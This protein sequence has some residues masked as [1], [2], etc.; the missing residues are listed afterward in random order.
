MHNNGSVVSVLALSAVLL[1]AGAS[2]AQPAAEQPPAAAQQQEEQEQEQAPEQDEQEPQQPPPDE[3]PTDAEDE[4]PTVAEEAEAE[5]GDEMAT[6]PEPQPPPAAGRR[7]TAPAAAEPA[8]SAPTITP[9]ALSPTGPWPQPD[10]DA[11]RLR[12]QGEARDTGQAQRE[13]TPDAQGVFAEDWWSHARPILE[14]HGYF[15]VRAELFHRMDLSRVNPPDDQLFPQPADSYYSNG[16]NTYG[17]VLCTADEAGLGDND[18]PN[19]LV[20]CRNRSLAGANLRFRLNPELHISD[21]LRVLSQVDLLDNLVLGSTPQGYALEPA[22]GGGYQTV[23]RGGYDPISLLD[24][25]QEPP[26][27]GVNGFR[28]SIRVK[29]AWAEYLTP[30]GEL[31][32]GRMPSHW[33][34]GILLNS[35]DGY[36]DDYQTTLDRIMFVTGVP[37]LDLFVAGAWDFPSEGATSEDVRQPQAQPYDAAQLDDVNQWALAIAKRKGAELTRLALAKGNLVLNGGAYLIY[38]KQLLANDLSG[39]V[40][41]G[42]YV[43]GAY[44]TAL[45]GPDG[46][47]PYVRRDAQIWTPDLWL[48]LL[49]KQFRF[50]LE[51]VTI[52]GSLE[53]TVSTGTNY[54]DYGGWKLRQYGIAT[55]IEQRLVE[56][57]LS[58]QF[59]FGWAS[60][61]PEA[62]EDLVGG[63]GLVPAPGAEMQTQ[64]GDDTFSTFRFHP[65]YRVDLILHRNILTRVQGDYYFRPSL[66]YDFMRSPNGQRF[67]GGFAGIWTRASEFMQTP[68]HRRDLG[69]ELNGQLY[70]QSKDGAL[71]DEPNH[72]GGFYTMLQYGV[73]FPLA[74]LGYQNDEAVD[75]RTNTGSNKSTDTKAA[76][77]LRWYLGV[78][79]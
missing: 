60:G 26:A 6:T 16:T 42:A 59:K 10:A 68:G 79:F 66:D 35:G 78:I 73:L 36:D 45:A 39:D 13:E 11:A 62:G 24:S 53:S 64:Y 32:F 20:R 71:N 72:M 33:G 31:R 22:A 69:I 21:N 46:T 54:G 57:R 7:P 38:R 1:G 74:G 15:R 3:Q 2:V 9:G 4:Q 27:S 55:E 28:D 8:P 37:S 5:P 67:G 23:R 17:P 29:R 44:P 70:F 77:L 75:I 50:E 61:D 63:G 76:Q 19:R 41:D 18:N 43:P 58:L 51:A 40:G 34:L 47:T 49:Y 65:N 25:T 12:Q 30:V 56:S 14:L 48:Q 52:Q